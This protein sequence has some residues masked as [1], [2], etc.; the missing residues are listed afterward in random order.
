MSHW[1]QT[2]RVHE[3][4]LGVL[5]SMGEDGFCTGRDERFSDVTVTIQ[6][7]PTEDA[8]MPRRKNTL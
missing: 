7:S 2:R 3:V 5:I 8:E 1:S 6:K 4:V